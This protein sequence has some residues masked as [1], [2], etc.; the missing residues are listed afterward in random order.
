MLR[1]EKVKE[2]AKSHG[3][4]LVGIG[5]MDRFVG[6]PLQ[7][8]PRHIFPE[9]SSIIG[10][11]FR[12]HNASIDDVNA[13][14]ILEEVGIFL[15][16]NGYDAILCHDTSVRLGRGVGKRVELGNTDVFLH[17]RIAATICGMGEIGL[18]N[19]FLSPE[20][21]PHQKLAFILTDAPLEPDPLFD[22][23]ICDRCMM[24]S[25]ECPAGAIDATKTVKITIAG[26]GFE[27]GELDTE[28]C[29]ASR[30]VCGARGCI[31]ACTIHL[32][33]TGKITK[34]LQ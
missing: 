13:P 21:G 27:W 25:K 2:F 12:I 10:L 14:I 8:D 32:E 11:G 6:A 17:F 34:H 5:S 9:V 3:A 4:D 22:G 15:Q 20:F 33:Q 1:A 23:K 24:C 29:S 16:D 30:Y 28:K 7:N 31:S 26:R 19:I 18:S